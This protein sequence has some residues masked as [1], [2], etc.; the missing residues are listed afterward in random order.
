M[1][2]INSMY[3]NELRLTN[4]SYMA[5]IEFINLVTLGLFNLMPFSTLP[6]FS[7]VA[8]KVATFNL[9]PNFGNY[10]I[11]PTKILASCQILAFAKIW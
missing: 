7:K 2:I 5:F 8:K 4:S 1:E 3:C 11:N 10:I 9:L 6:N